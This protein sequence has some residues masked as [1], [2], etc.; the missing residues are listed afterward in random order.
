MPLS[1]PTRRALSSISFGLGSVWA[2]AGAFKLLFGVRL[3]LFFLPPIGLERVSV[4]PALGI[5]VGFFAV[6]ALLA[7]IP[8]RVAVDTPADVSPVR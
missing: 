2:V 7:R 1:R 4:A 3:T 6:A 5:A 8:H